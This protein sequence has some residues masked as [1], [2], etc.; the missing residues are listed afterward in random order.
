MQDDSLSPCV[1]SSLWCA[2]I[3]LQ[4]TI[5]RAWST[6]FILHDNFPTSMHACICSAGTPMHHALES[7]V[8]LTVGLTDGLDMQGKPCL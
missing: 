2:N 1:F 7:T 8:G 5:H 6:D 3:M 4:V